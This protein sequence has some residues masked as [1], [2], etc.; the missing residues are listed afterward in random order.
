MDISLIAFIGT[1]DACRIRRSLVLSSL[2]GRFRRIVRDRSLSGP[3]LVCLT[4]LVMQVSAKI[5]VYLSNTLRKSK[6]RQ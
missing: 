6:I 1:D 3:G 4:C 2:C 5:S